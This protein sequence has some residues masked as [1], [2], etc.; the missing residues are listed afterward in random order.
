M[1]CTKVSIVPANKGSSLT[2]KVALEKKTDKPF[3]LISL[4][5]LLNFA[6][7]HF[8]RLLW[9]FQTD[10]FAMLLSTLRQSTARG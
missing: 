8:F 1:V 7:Y 3:R 9:Q 5:Y 10:R 6:T 4:N 2:S